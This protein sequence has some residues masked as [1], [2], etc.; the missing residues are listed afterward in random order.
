MA[1]NGR[2]FKQALYLAQR[3]FDRVSRR[4]GFNNDCVLCRLPCADLTQLVCDV[5]YQDLDLIELGCEFLRHHPKQASALVCR[6]IQGIAA[7]SHYVWPFSQFIPSLKFHNASIHAKWFGQML[8]QQVYYQLWPS[9]DKVIPIPL[10][11]LRQFQRGYNQSYLIAKHM[12]GYAELVDTQV[13]FRE[14]FTKPQT[15]LNKQQ[16]K[17]NVKQAFV[18]RG[19]VE[20]LTILLIDDVI[21]TGN[22]LDQAAKVLIEKG[23]TAVY[24]AAVA[25]RTLN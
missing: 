9:F 8:E 7:V 17:Q 20:G 14:V 1:N 11:P 2:Q 21:T 25:I 3:L 15:E 23:A 13:L 5:C 6:H 18:C 22:T 16:R 10:H 12:T 24:V 19:K 4:F